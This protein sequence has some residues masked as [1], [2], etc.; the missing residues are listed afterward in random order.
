VCLLLE[1][2]YGTRSVPATRS[3]GRHTECACYYTTVATY[4]SLLSAGHFDRMG[5]FM[6]KLPTLFDE[7]NEKFAA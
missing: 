2:A 5:A 7:L 6:L 3:C 4:V 1:A